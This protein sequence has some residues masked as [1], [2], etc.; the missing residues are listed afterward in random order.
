M[1]LKIREAH[2]VEGL[3][4]WHLDPLEQ[5]DGVLGALEARALDPQVVTQLLDAALDRVA[6]SDDGGAAAAASATAA[7]VVLALGRLTR[8][9]LV[10]LK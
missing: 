1:T 10:V 3:L 5:L 9:L 8:R 6:G 4:V 7:D 2:L